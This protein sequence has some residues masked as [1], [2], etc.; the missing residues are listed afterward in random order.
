MFSL[1]KVDICI[2]LLSCF[3][4]FALIWCGFFF[5]RKNSKC[6]CNYIRVLSSYFFCLENAEFMLLCK[7]TRSA[8]FQCKHI[9][10]FKV[11]CFIGFC[12]S[13]NCY[14]VLEFF[15]NFVMNKWDSLQH[16]ERIVA[17]ERYVWRT[18]LESWKKHVE[19][20]KNIFSIWNYFVGFSTEYL[21]Q[22]NSFSQKYRNRNSC[23]NFSPWTSL[24]IFIM[25]KNVVRFLVSLV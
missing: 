24:V 1:F 7:L 20:N 19:K 22:R 12:C 8:L 2:F 23:L 9:A 3:T 14:C 11:R 15:G 17:S 18:N 5:K 21:Q 4:Y 13:C 16:P 25:H 10:N 6:A